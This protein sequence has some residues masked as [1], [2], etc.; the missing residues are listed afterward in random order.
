[1]PTNLK[2]RNNM[3]FFKIGKS[4]P[5]DV[6]TLYIIFKFKQFRL[7]YYI[8]QKNSLSISFCSNMGI[9]I[10]ILKYGLFFSWDNR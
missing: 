8:L 1:M 5:Y 3:K 9:Y 4:Y 7:S 6:F 10:D 2:E